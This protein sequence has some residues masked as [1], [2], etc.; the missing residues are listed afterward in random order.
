MI[1]NQ[2]DWWLVLLRDVFRV[3]ACVLLGVL[4]LCRLTCQLGT[5][6]YLNRKHHRNDW[7]FGCARHCSFQ[8][9]FMATNPLDKG[10]LCVPGTKVEAQC[11]RNSVLPL[12]QLYSLV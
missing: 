11:D 6:L 4:T 10:I 5:D 3:K 2:A 8:L 7:R 12:S 9:V 1:N